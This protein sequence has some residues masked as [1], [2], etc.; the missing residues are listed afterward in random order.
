MRGRLRS[1]NSRA[2]Y[3]VRWRA[4]TMER[5]LLLPFISVIEMPVDSDTMSNRRSTVMGFSGVS[6]CPEELVEPEA[7]QWVG[8]RRKRKQQHGS[9]IPPAP[10][11]YQAHV[12]LSC[13]CLLYTSDAADDLLCVDLGGR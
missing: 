4:R 3:M 8:L 10:G 6:G 5:V 1:V 9:N 2:R 11:C 12:K 7:R 13:C